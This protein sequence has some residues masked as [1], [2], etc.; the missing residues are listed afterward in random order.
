MHQGSDSTNQEGPT[1]REVWKAGEG[2][3]GG[4][5]KRK[6]ENDVSTIN[7]NQ[8]NFFQNSKYCK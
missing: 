7:I 6:K 4:E 8:C 3:E 1:C 5:R 2:R